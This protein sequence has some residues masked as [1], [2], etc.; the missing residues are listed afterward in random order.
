MKI[1]IV[2]PAWPYRGGIAA[3]NERLAQQLISE[4]HEV[5]LYTF[6]LQ[7]PSLLFPGSTQYSSEPAPV[8][9]DIVRVLNSINPYSWYKVGKLIAAE[10]PDI[11]IMAYW[12]PFMAPAM[13]T[14]ARMVKRNGHTRVLGLLHNLLPH[15]HRPGDK[16]LSRFMVKS[17]HGVIALSQ[18]VCAEVQRF[19]PV[20]PAVF[21]P[22]PL[23]DNF[24]DAVSRDEACQ[25]LNLDPNCRYLL[26]FGLIRDYKGLDLLFDAMHRLKSVS[27]GRLLCQWDGGQRV[28][29]PGP[30]PLEDD[31]LMMGRS[32]MDEEMNQRA[33]I[34][35]ERPVRLIVAG[36]FYSGRERYLELARALGIYDDVEWRT[37]FVPNSEVRHYFSAADL[38]VQPYR[39]ATQSGVTQIAYHFEKPML[40]TNVGGLAE[41]VPNGKVGYVV[42]PTPRHIADALEVFLSAHDKPDF[43][44]GLRSEKKRY[45][46]SE[47]TKNITS[48]A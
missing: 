46:W 31:L 16:L 48:L 34:R 6:T 25:H 43:A 13:G 41:I 12:M 4:G 45:S 30:E 47:I 18:S 3:F 40:V 24:G 1:Q 42:E 7:Y 19:A 38:V 15:E 9:L 36:E 2:G 33:Q 17:L 44:E 37:Q 14:V 20:M 26:F 27:R 35:S 21:S 32:M 23:Y 5:K 8:G 22:H 39:N 29:S 28:P 11:L 10:A